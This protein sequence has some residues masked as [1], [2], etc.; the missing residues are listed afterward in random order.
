LYARYGV[1]GAQLRTAGIELPRWAFEQHKV[2]E[3]KYCNH[4]K[5]HEPEKIDM[6]SVVDGKTCTYEQF[7]RDDAETKQ[8]D[9]PVPSRNLDTVGSC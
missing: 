1:A 7:G 2:C 4:D 9:N 5:P 6:I 8:T 3:A